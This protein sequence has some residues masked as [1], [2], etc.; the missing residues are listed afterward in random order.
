MTSTQR[1][2]LVTIIC[3][4]TLLASVVGVA[5]QATQERRPGARVFVQNGV[6][7]ESGVFNYSTQGDNTF[8]FVSSEM[9]FDGK[10]V[11]GAPYSAQVVTESVQTLAD[12]NRIVRRNTAAVYRDGEGRTRREQSINAVGAFSAAG[13]PQQMIFINDPVAGVNYILDTKNRTA[14]KMEFAGLPPMKKWIEEG[15]KPR[16]G[17]IEQQKAGIDQQKT[18]IMKVEVESMAAA[19]RAAGKMMPPPGPGMAFEHSV[20][21]FDEKNTK[22]ESLGKQTVEGV[23][24]EGT[25]FT[26]TIAA[27]E[28]GNEAP[29]NIVSETWYSPELQTVV[30]SKHSDPRLGENTYRL[31]GINRSEPARALFEVPSDYTVKETM[32]PGM[33]YKIENEIR[34]PSSNKQ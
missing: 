22:K 31:T 33:R 7:G 24:A 23:E 21:K 20:M 10:L 32:A 3:M 25:R 14:R 19:G 27:G 34:K 16:E 18:A 5:A 6:G 8:V 11:K 4:F 9:S 26:H 15:A 30:M 2:M 28:I 13:E 12:G 17:T 29:I 1:R